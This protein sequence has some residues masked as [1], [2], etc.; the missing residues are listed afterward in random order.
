MRT[1]SIINT[2]MISQIYEAFKKSTGISTDTRTVTKG[3]MFIALKGDNFDANNMVADA[4][5]KGAAYVVTSN[6]N[7]KDDRR[8][9][10]VPDTLLAL[11][12]LAT[13]HRDSLNI[14][15]IGITGTNGKTTTKELITAVLSRKFKTFATKGNLNNQIGVPLTILS[16]PPD[17]EI[18]VVEM[19]A[20]HPN[21]I[22]ELVDIAHPTTGLITNVGIA[23]LQGFGS[24]DG[25]KRTKGELYDY[26]RQNDGLIFINA[27]DPDLIDLLGNYHKFHTYVSGVPVGN[28]ELLTVRFRLDDID[29]DIHTQLTGKYNTT[30]VRAAVTVGSF[31][32]VLVSDIC[33]AIEAYKPTNSRSQIVQTQ[34]NRLILDAYNANPSSM[35]ASLDNFQTINAKNKVVILGAMRE[36]GNEQ[37]PQHAAILDRLEQMHLD[38][39]ILIGEEFAKFQDAHPAFSFFLSAQE[40]LPKAQQL[41]GKY[42]LVKGSNSNHL[43]SLADKL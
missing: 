16:I 26:L 1:E 29:Y 7:F 30:N 9:F 13:T 24:F 42:I 6:E 14:P 12:H 17:A 40:A 37:D 27:N 28:D 11:Q 25:V 5:D 22:K 21:D 3:N 36:L 41:S 10:I 39:A 38:D 2:D 20:S 31:F 8:A 32:H 34:R 19:G 33:A 15:V 18:A 23:H 4:L 43:S 35:N